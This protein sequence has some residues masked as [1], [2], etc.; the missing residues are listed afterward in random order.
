MESGKPK[1]VHKNCA[2]RPFHC[3]EIQQNLTFIAFHGNYAA[4][5]GVLSASV[6]PFV[7]RS[8]GARKP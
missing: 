5:C 6:H 3:P 2:I 7:Q 1:D 8:D 4:W